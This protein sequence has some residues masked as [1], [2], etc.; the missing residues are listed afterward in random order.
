MDSGLDASLLVALEAATATEPA[1]NS[2][3][4]IIYPLSTRA[5]GGTPTALPRTRTAP[6]ATSA[7]HIGCRPLRGQR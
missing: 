1:M 4:E 3:L 6:D 7:S 5:A 2:R